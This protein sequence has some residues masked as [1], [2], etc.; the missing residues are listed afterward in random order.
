MTERRNNSMFNDSCQH[1]VRTTRQWNEK[2][3]DKWP[4]P[5]GCLCVELTPDG[6]TYL[7]IGTGRTPFPFLQYISTDD[8]VYDYYTKDEIDTIIHNLQNLKIVSDRIYVNPETLPKDNNHLGDIRFVMS[9][10]PGAT[11]PME[12]VWTNVEGAYQWTPLGADLYGIDFSQ[13]VTK[14]ELEP[15]LNELIEKSH[16]HDNKQILDNTTASY[17]EEEQLFLNDLM[18]SEGFTG[19]TDTTDGTKGLVPQ[20]RAGDNDKYLK[21]DGTW[22]EPPPSGVIDVTQEDPHNLNEL[23]IHF[24]DS[25]KT[26]DIPGGDVAYTSVYEMESFTLLTEKPPD[27]ST[28]WMNYYSLSYDELTSEPP[29]FDPTKH[30]YFNGSYHVHG[31]PGDTWDSGTWYDA[32]Y[33]PLD[34][35]TYVPFTP[36]KYYKGEIK[37]ISDGEQ[38][39][40][41]FGK[42]N[43]AIQI[44]DGEIASKVNVR[45]DEGDTENLIIY[46]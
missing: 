37:L 5:R 13:Y 2:P 32:H 22:A 33:I 36:G 7:K 12:Y 31:E 10:V 17:T 25:S 34:N 3:L 20:P 29:R 44:L 41:S 15:V 19:A 45:M 18:N 23:T 26:I 9:P 38:L 35:T 27:W 1:I 30:Y 11:F 46:H 42:L 14:E 4:V 8:N 6:K 28:H 24:T 40:D 39:G 43:E 16:T 21:G